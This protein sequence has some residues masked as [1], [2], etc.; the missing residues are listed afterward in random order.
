MNDL[1]SRKHETV[2]ADHF[3]SLYTKKTDP[4]DYKTSSFEAYK[5]SKT[6]GVL[7]GRAFNKG[8]ELGC[9]IGVLTAELAAH[10]QSLIGVDGSQT[11][12]DLAR[13]ALKNYPNVRII[14][15]RFPE[16]VRV[17][18]ALGQLDLLILSE[19]LYFFSA[20]DMQALAS[21]VRTSLI[22]GGQCIVVNFDG[23]TQAGFSG[24][25]ADQ[26]FAH[27]TEDCLKL[28]SRDIYIGFQVVSYQRMPH[29][30]SS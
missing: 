22:A 17:L 29:D 7:N 8:L 25:E 3:E 1:N 12:C 21:Y 23:D 2:P 11:A 5:R 27:L 18:E 30:G 6:V 9:S 14:Q 15:A 10:C 13:T 20:N 24:F 26:L 19:V 16:D 28:V 4:W